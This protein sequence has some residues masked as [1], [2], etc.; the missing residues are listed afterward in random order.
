MRA[1]NLVIHLLNGLLVFLL[2]RSIVRVAIAR[3]PSRAPRPDWFALLISCAW[4]TSPINFTAVAYIVQ[5]MESLAQLFVLSGLLLYI[6]GRIRMQTTGR[7]FAACAASLTVC[8]ALG[9]MCKE[10]AL[11]LPLYAAIAEWTI[12]GFRSRDGSPDKR[13][14]W[15]YIICLAL[16]MIAGGLWTAFTYLPAAAW[17]GR[18]FTL[19]QRLLTE[20]RIILDYARWS[21][22]PLPHQ[23]S[24][25]HDDIALSTSVFRPWSTLVCILTILAIFTAGAASRRSRPLLSLGL[26]WFVAAHLMTGTVI[27]LELAFEHR[28]YF[29]VIGLYIATLDVFSEARW[30]RLS[31]TLAIAL[32][33]GLLAL[34][35]SVTNVRALQWGNEL[36]WAEGEVHK[37][38]KSAR[39]AFELGRT[40]FDRAEQ[41]H[42][43]DSTAAAF[44][45]LEH[46][47]SMPEA[48]ALADQALSLLY[49]YS[50][51]DVPAY[52]WHRL[53]NKLATQPLT[54][55]NI[56]ALYTLARC[57]IAGA[58][59]FPHEV[60]KKCFDAAL[61]RSPSNVAVL[62]MY[63]DFANN[64]LHDSSLAI[65]LGKQA[66]TLEPRNIDLRINV[67]ILLQ[68]NGKID[69][70]RAFYRQTEREL[71]NAR[72]NAAFREWSELISAPGMEKESAD[73]AK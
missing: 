63:A 62:S 20:P 31:K 33:L 56:G 18:P 69:E 47:A 12:F 11:L 25:F 55:E 37:R 34:F 48:N 27:P 50:G 23:L 44:T 4:L 70:A 66:V 2:V 67:L 60:L 8:T 49:A 68:T 35:A 64:V 58:C 15:L 1:V 46:A 5:R 22:L 45:A 40:Y 41:K 59:R 65:E 24:L 53:E 21:L 52:V 10:T 61:A 28:N 51:R 19:A 72:Q 54:A 36:T 7:G 6:G 17:Q 57:E 38:P 3:S 13:I 42:D 73:P 14:R 16:P 39:A 29:A 26:L 71:Q 30:F 43:V 9:A 32:C